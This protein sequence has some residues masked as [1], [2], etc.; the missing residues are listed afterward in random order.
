MKKL[1]VLLILLL[2]AGIA[3]ASVARSATG[4]ADNRASAISA[5]KDSASARYG[6]RIE[7]WGDTDCSTKTVHPNSYDPS[8]T[9]TVWVCTVD[10]TTKD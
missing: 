2:T 3:Y 5:A 8:V 6:D 10:F 4:Q 7:S 1:V 9:A